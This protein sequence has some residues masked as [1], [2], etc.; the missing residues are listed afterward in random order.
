MGYIKNPTPEQKRAWAKKAKDLKDDAFAMVRQVAEEYRCNP[1]KMIEYFQFA[2]QFYTYSPNNVALIY[3]QNRGATFVQSFKGWKDMGAS[4]LANASGI[5]ILTPTP[6]TYLQINDDT[7]IKLSNATKKQKELYKQGLIESF[8][9]MNFSVGYVFDISQTTFPKERYPEIFTMGRQSKSHAR[10]TNALIKFSEQEIQCPVITENIESISLRGYYE[11]LTH[12]IVLNHLMDDT[13]RLS[14]M[15]H[16]L[17]HALVHYNCPDRSTAQKEFEGDALSL[18]LLERNGIP[19]EDLRKQHIATHYNVFKK[20]CENEILK[21]SEN[22][23]SQE[24]IDE[25]INDML[26]KSFSNVFSVCQDYFD[27]IDS[28][29]ENE[30]LVLEE[31]SIVPE[32]SS[33]N[34]AISASDIECSAGISERTIH[35]LKKYGVN[36]DFIKKCMETHLLQDYEELACVYHSPEGKI[37]VP[38]NH[39]V[40]PTIMDTKNLYYAA[41]QKELC[42]TGNRM[43]YLA[44]VSYGRDVLL[45]EK[46]DLQEVEQLIDK[47]YQSFSWGSGL[48]IEKET[49][50]KRLPMHQKPFI[51]SI[52]MPD[53]EL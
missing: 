4:V 1:E 14:T 28:Y 19:L 20:E 2:S 32:T 53:I 31:P 13:E 23:L 45:I 18:M 41:D 47:S 42:I 52:K 51:E 10:I 22:I 6:T 9:K 24:E 3:H 27:T 16:E 48:M 21:S 40:V 26:Q 37:I 39:F 34:K 38:F 36:P 35:T 44:N 15:S 17:G 46:K 5:H 12:R 30:K 29:I 33:I 50:S 43:E 11:P 25:K 7:V 8:Q 49:L